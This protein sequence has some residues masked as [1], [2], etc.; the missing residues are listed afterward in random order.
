MEI[1]QKKPMDSR[2][3]GCGDKDRCSDVYARIGSQQGPSVAMKVVWAFLVPIIL[4]IAGLIFSAKILSTG[5]ESERA[6]TAV[7]VF[8]GLF[9]VGIYLTAVKTMSAV[10]RNH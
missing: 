9:L 1:E 6:A 10:R 3:A 7:N 8:A 5:L 4:F 2:C